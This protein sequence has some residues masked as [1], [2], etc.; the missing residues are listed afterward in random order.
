MYSDFRVAFD[1]FRRIATLNL[2]CMKADRGLVGRPVWLVPAE[3]SFFFVVVVV[4]VILFLS[5]IEFI[6]LQRH[7]VLMK[8]IVNVS[9][10]GRVL[11]KVSF[12]SFFLFFLHFLISLF[13]SFSWAWERMMSL[14]LLLCY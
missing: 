12:S 14:M 2:S 5:F 13:L 10:L 4:V 3:V 1:A 11:A 7:Y 8:K 9:K 6:F